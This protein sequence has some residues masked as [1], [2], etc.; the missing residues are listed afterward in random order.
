MLPAP[1][2]QAPTQES[3][4]TGAIEIVLGGG[5]RV[6]VGADVDTEALTRIIDALERRR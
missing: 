2:V 1:A 4:N 6:R 5:R 3:A